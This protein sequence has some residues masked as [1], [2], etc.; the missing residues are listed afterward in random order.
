MEGQKP[1]V[2]PSGTESPPDGNELTLA[3][4]LSCHTQFLRGIR[5]AH[6]RFIKERLERQYSICHFFEP[7]VPS[8]VPT[9][10]PLRAS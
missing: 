2:L 3:Q 7:S 1:T 5:R 9:D 6:R 8:P 4:L 10:P